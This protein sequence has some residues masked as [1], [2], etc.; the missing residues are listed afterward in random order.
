M[1]K[2]GC[3][4]S[5]SEWNKSSVSS[6]SRDWSK[7]TNNFSIISFFSNPLL[8]SNLP[9]MASGDPRQVLLVEMLFE[10]IVSLLSGIL[11]YRFSIG[12]QVL[13]LLQKIYNRD[14]ITNSQNK[15]KS[16]PQRM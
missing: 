14:S 4:E 15:G 5:K 11:L 9:Y 7:N 16:Y 12:N 2:I 1:I 8:F 13:H 10:S 3:G 6:S